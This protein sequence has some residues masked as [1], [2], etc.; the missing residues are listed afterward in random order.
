MVRGRQIAASLSKGLSVQVTVGQE[1]PAW[2]VPTVVKTLPGNFVRLSFKHPTGGRM[3][4]DYPRTK[5]LPL[6][7]DAVRPGEEKPKTPQG[8]Q[9]F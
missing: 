1:A 5:Q 8:E 2:V 6:H 4:K 3:T 9:L 7:P